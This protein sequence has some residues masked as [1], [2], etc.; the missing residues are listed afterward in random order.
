MIIIITINPLVEL[1]EFDVVYHSN[2][3]QNTF[4]D[5]MTEQSHIKYYSKIFS[6]QTHIKNNGQKRFTWSITGNSLKMYQKYQ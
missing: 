1:S 2:K 6:E 4:N 3:L 5:K